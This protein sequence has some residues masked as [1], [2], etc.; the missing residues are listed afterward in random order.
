MA[1]E[2]AVLG[3]PAVFVSTT[4]R[5]YTDEQE[6]RYGLVHNFTPE[7]EDEALARVEELLARAD[8]AAD[9][10][11]GGRASWPTRS[12]S[13]PGWSTSSRAAAERMGR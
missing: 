11:A 4:G 3:T 8:L 6:R 7:R 12:T 10:A 13:R 9:A 1:S 2:A 5:G